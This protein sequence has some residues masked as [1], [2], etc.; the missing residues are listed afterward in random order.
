M[1]PVTFASSF[2]FSMLFPRIFSIDELASILIFLRVVEY[3][4][5]LLISGL[6]YVSLSSF[7]LT[8]SYIKFILINFLI[9]LTY[10]LFNDALELSKLV[11]A[12]SAIS[13]AFIMYKSNMFVRVGKV[14]FGTFVPP[15]ALKFSVIL[16]VVHSAFNLENAMLFLCLVASIYWVFNPKAID[17][18][19]SQRSPWRLWSF[20]VVNRLYGMTVLSLL[21]NTTDDA[22]LVGILYLVTLSQ[23]IDVCFLE[24]RRLIFLQVPKIKNQNPMIINFVLIVI[25]GL[26][27]AGGLSLI[28][29][30]LGLPSGILEPELFYI[31]LGCIFLKNIIGSRIEQSFYSED[32]KHILVM[33]CVTAV[34]FCINFLGIKVV[35]NLLPLLL[36]PMLMFQI[37]YFGWEN[38]SRIFK[39]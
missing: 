17:N 28:E 11:T 20:D 5:G 31:F 34:I 14:F 26:A 29:S 4:S 37:S 10:I 3:A 1:Y 13:L 12:I 22:N 23:V 32:G 39:N 38:L 25:A 18:P 2:A 30:I 8:R 19:H 35:P 21:V 16:T 6:R 24:G 7:D 27:S 15:I 36:T 9:T 33:A